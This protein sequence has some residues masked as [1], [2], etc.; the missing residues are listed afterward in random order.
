MAEEANENCDIDELLND[1]QETYQN[2][3]EPLHEDSSNFDADAQ[4]FYKLL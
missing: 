4:A 1:I 3:D 2:I